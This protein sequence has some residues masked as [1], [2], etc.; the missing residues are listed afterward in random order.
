MSQNSPSQRSSSLDLIKSLGLLLVIFY[1]ITSTPDILSSGSVFNALGYFFYPFLSCCVPLF[2]MVSGALALSRPMN[3]RKNT[4]R[5]IHLLIITLLWLVLCLS[6]VLLL[7]GE[8]VSLQ[9]F[10]DIATELRVG[11]VQHL[12]YL[13]NFLFLCA[14][15]PVLQSLKSHTPKIYGYFLLLILVLTFGNM[16]LNDLEYLLRW[17]LGNQ[18][19]QGYRAFFW[20]P[21]YF[22]YHYWYSFVY[23]ALGDYMLSN[24]QRLGRF[25]K[26]CPFTI[27]LSMGALAL[28]GVAKSYVKG[29][30]SDTVFYNYSDPF[31]L[32]LTASVFLLLQE[33]TLRSGLQKLTQSL[34]TCSL[35]I[36]VTHWLFLE[37][38]R[39]FL[40]QLTDS[41]I[42]ALPV[43]V[44]VLLA[45]W[46]LCFCCLKVPLVKNLFTATPVWIKKYS[47][48][49]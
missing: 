28:I 22:D 42:L 29:S 31:T 12:W 41:A 33:V 38:L 3:L 24:R 13:P 23:F 25:R 5:C 30:L 2:F 47:Q 36:Y 21:N 34:A 8:R 49:A 7:R 20:Y 45:S 37:A 18:G 35:G 19:Y 43:S 46:A 15:L 48:A 11:Y 4:L 27:L 10:W 17:V 6:I 14:L 26:L 39:Q 40:P 1:H 32:L 44:L 9:E 16:L